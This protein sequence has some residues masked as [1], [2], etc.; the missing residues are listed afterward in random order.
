MKTP[1]LIAVRPTPAVLEKHGKPP[2]TVE[3]YE[4]RR[5][6]VGTLDQNAEYL[7][8]DL[9]AGLSI[10]W[11]FDLIDQVTITR[12]TEGDNS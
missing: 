1:W 8:M 12:R 7:I 3:V 2:N 4:P 11:S 9:D 5:W 10:R 6:Y